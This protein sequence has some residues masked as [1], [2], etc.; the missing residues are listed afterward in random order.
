MKTKRCFKC[1]REQRASE[2]YRHP[3]M[4]DGLLGKCKSCAKKDVRANYA[5]KR[6]ERSAYER[7]RNKTPK[8]RAQLALYQLLRRQRNPEKAKAWRAVSNA[9]R[10]GRL[11][12]APCEQCG[13]ARSQGHHDDYS[14]PLDVRW[15][16]FSCHRKEHG[17][18]VIAEATKAA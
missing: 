8:R 2:F 16:C 4:S 9:V 11:V 1:Q 7:K 12:R 15:L 17:Q 13:D 6:V 18:V 3:G 14:K 10:A 5:A